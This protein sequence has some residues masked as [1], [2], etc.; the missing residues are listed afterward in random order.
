MWSQMQQSL[1]HF[2]GHCADNWKLWVFHVHW[3]VR[4]WM[5]AECML[6]AIHINI[7]YQWSACTMYPDQ[8]SEGSAPS[9]KFWRQR[10][11]LSRKSLRGTSWCLRSDHKVRASEPCS[12]SRIWWNMLNAGRILEAFIHFIHLNLRHVKSCYSCKGLWRTSGDPSVLACLSFKKCTAPAYTQQE[13]V[14]A[15]VPRFLM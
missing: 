9:S 5:H 2:L 1:L 12:K 10:N 4:H 6:N 8:A 3:N 13:I 7:K 11:V 15:I 14:P